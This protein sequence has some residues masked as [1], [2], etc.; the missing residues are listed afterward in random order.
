MG[1]YYYFDD[2]FFITMGGL[3]IGVMGLSIRYCY[4]MKI[5]DL[6]L[7]WGCISIKRDVRGEEQLDEH[8]MDLRLVGDAEENSNSSTDII[9]PPS[10]RISLI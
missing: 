9:P 4:K 6:E 10:R 3:V 2:V 8:K 1:W 5:K 7:C